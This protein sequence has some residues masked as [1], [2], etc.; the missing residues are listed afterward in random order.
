MPSWGPATSGPTL[1]WS[2]R[3]SLRCLCSALLTYLSQLAPEH[4]MLMS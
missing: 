1:L 2:S 4:T 3:M